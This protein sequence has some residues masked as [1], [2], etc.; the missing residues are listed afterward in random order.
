MSYIYILYR[1]DSALIKI[2]HTKFSGSDRASNYTDGKW[3]VYK[4]YEVPSFLSASIER[5]THELLKAQG[6]WVDPLITNGT[7]VEIFNCSKNEG[8]NCVK[9]AMELI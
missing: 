7:A 9:K 3:L 4:E 8:D 6:V 1:S 2:G 5:K